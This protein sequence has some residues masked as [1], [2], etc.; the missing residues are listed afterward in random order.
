MTGPVSPVL[1]CAA[2]VIRAGAHA[3]ITRAMDNCNGPTHFIAFVLDAFGRRSES[4]VI[5]KA[6]RFLLIIVL[7]IFLCQ[8]APLRAALTDT[9]APAN[10]VIKVL[11]KDAK[12]EVT[13]MQV[14]TMAGSFDLD[15]L[16]KNSV[17]INNSDIPSTL[18]M[19]G[20]L[21]TINEQKG[22]LKLFLGRTVPYVTSSSSNGS[23]AS[24][25]QISVGLNAAFVV[26]FGKPLVIQVDDSGEV[27]VLV[28]REEN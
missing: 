6:I 22:M 16:Q 21:T 13:T 24:Y 17:K 20:G 26:T 14:T 1:L 15:T 7:G 3:S 5:M 23:V 28:T 4:V 11:M 27:T 25:S 19:S 12:G 2:D 8:A 10:Y 18:K 9:N